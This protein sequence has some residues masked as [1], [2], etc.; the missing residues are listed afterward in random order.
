MALHVL[1]NTFRNIREKMTPV[2]TSS[3]LEEGRLNPEQFVVAG[4]ALVKLA[5]SWQWEGGDESKQRSYLPASKQ[6]LVTRGV[7]CAR[8]AKDLSSASEAGFGSGGGR[9]VEHKFGMTGTTNSK[10]ASTPGRR[11]E[12]GSVASTE[13][14]GV[15]SDKGEEEEVEGWIEPG[16][17]AATTA[18][19]P[20]AAAAAAEYDA[21]PELGR[22]Y[23]ELTE[24]ANTVDPSIAAM[25]DPA[26]ITPSQRAPGSAGGGSAGRLGQRSTSAAI[27]QQPGQH[28]HSALPSLPASPLSTAGGGRTG[29]GGSAPSLR[30]YDLFITYD[31]YYRRVL[32]WYACRLSF[33]EWAPCHQR[34]II[35]V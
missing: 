32:L 6:Y 16:S 13:P 34:T 2:L 24:V 5:P 35:A 28:V 25:H 10:P 33:S 11:S 26:A 29:A 27:G 17:A 4:D 14:G 18:T 20:G 30:R 7:P 22:A 19:A 21:L 23:A 3:Q 8:R 12:A 1:L 31:N 9:D 15:Q